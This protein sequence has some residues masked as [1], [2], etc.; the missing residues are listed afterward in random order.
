M[1]STRGDD[2]GS[3]SCVGSAW[4]LEGSIVD[5]PIRRVHWISGSVA[6]AA[7]VDLTIVHEMMPHILD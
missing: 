3:D 4:V 5:R 6:I 1:R 2:V 7:S